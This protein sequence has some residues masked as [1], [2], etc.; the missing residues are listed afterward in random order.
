MK[1]DN[2]VKIFSALL[3]LLIIFICVPNTSGQTKV[4][5][6]F[7]D[8]RSSDLA[9]KIYK[10]NGEWEFYWNKHLRPSDFRK[11]EKPVP[12]TWGKVP[13]Y[14]IKYTDEIPGITNTG[15]ASYRVN[16]LFPENISEV[17]FDIPVFDAAFRIYI[18][19][20]Y[21]GGNGLA[22]RNE[23]ESKPGYKPFTYIHKITDETVEVIINVSN[24]HHR[25]GGFW[26]PMKVGVPENVSSSLER[27]NSISNICTGLLLAFAAFFFI[28][29]I[30]F[31]GNDASLFFALA[32]VGILLRGIST[33]SYPVLTFFDINWITLIRLEYTGSFIALIFGAW[34]FY[35]IFP[36]RYFKIICTIITVLFSLG[37][38]LVLSSPVLIFSQTTRIFM[39]AI[40]LILLY[41][42]AR[43]IISLLKAERKG[44][45][46]TVGFIALLI[47]VINDSLLSTSS[48]FLFDT[49]ILPYFTIIFICM[50]VIILI[51]MWVNSLK[52]EKRLLAE[53]EYVNQN[54]EKIINKRTSELANQKSELERQKEEIQK[55][56]EELKKNIIIKNRVFSIIA[57]DLKTPVVSLAMLIDNTRNLI[58]E[59]K[60][61]T[62]IDEVG[63]QVDFTINLI[64]NLLVWGK[65]Q[66]DL[67]DYRPGK[68]KM[69][70]IVLDC[71]NQLNA[72]AE[73]KGIQ[74]SYS[75]RGS[76]EAWC[77]RNLVSIILR[78]LL[79]NSIKFTPDKGK[80]YVSVEEI[81]DINPYLKVSV[82]DTGVGIDY[83]NLVKMRKNEIIK[84]TMGTMGEK[85]TGL[86]IQLCHDLIKISRGKMDIS[87]TRGEGTTISFTLPTQSL[88]GN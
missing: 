54:L 9:D 28:F 68:W 56:N 18:D 57:H 17:A 81:T 7:I 76:P 66:Q 8:L 52:E 71:F 20:K 33:G 84:S 42:G 85:G 19:G 63:K 34:Y 30:V 43:S 60:R 62:L 67:I 37:I 69:T 41:Y 14:W 58:G 15:F 27:Q 44:I 55:T 59:E 39:P 61:E 12:D 75:H 24:F 88:P 1:R 2:S 10:L 4:E 21:A 49:Y 77:D 51:S 50:Q 29:F 80:I 32:S 53:L 25:R 72:R 36:N 5:K 26:M 70:D 11:T 86:G 31:R 38:M 40:L 79:T 6:G 73:I 78:N 16:I 48:T 83:D 64:D 74:L 35:R 3:K 65:A 46:N 87:S 82:R 23:A 22:G 13:S 45:L 47:G